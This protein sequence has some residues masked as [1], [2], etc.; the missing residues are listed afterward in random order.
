MRPIS[1]KQREE[2]K[3]P[4]APIP[5]PSLLVSLDDGSH[6]SAK[7][8]DFF[9]TWGKELKIHAERFLA[10]IFILC[11]EGEYNWKKEKCKAAMPITKKRRYCPENL[12]RQAAQPQKNVSECLQWC[13]LGRGKGVWFKILFHHPKKHSIP[14][15]PHDSIPITPGI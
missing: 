6:A 1:P 8:N 4:L 10:K 3:S 12:R 7:E 13:C 9:F 5:D 15:Y 2:M 11:G 14:M